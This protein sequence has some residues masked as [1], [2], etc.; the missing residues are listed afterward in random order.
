MIVNVNHLEEN[1]EYQ[2]LISVKD[3]EFSVDAYFRFGQGDYEVI[4]SIPDIEQ[5]DQSMFY[6]TSVAKVNQ[7]VIDIEDERGQLPAWGIE[8]DHPLIIEK[9]EAITA[10]LDQEREKAKA[11][12]EFVAKHVTYDV[13]KRSEE[14]RVGKEC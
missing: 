9:A 12:Y 11:I 13:E 8:S 4:I 14:R 3:Y 6:Y 5:E 7:E 10:G 1:Q 2:Y